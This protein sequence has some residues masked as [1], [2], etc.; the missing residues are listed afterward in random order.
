[1]T[2]QCRLR[3]RHIFRPKGELIFMDKRA[4]GKAAEP[5]VLRQGNAMAVQSR[6]GR[7]PSPRRFSALALKG[8]TGLVSDAR[9]RRH[10]E[11]FL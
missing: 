1:L 10:L 8:M 9:S 2:L 11:A 5:E 7:R 3:K 4:F 6:R